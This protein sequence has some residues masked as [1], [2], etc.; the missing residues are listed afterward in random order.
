MLFTASVRL[1][2]NSM[3]LYRYGFNKYEISLVTGLPSQELDK[4]AA[5]LI[6]YFTNDQEFID[7]FVEKDGQPF[8]LFNER[9]IGHLKD[10]KGLFKLAFR[11]L[12][13]TLIYTVV[14]IG[15]VYMLWQDKRRVARGLIGGSALTLGLMAIAGLIIWIDFDWFF[16]QFHFISFANDLWLLD[17]TR[18]YLIMMFPQGFWFDATVIIASGTGA[19]ALALGLTG[20]WRLN[21]IEPEKPAQ[22][23]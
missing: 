6:T 18:D 9:E 15:F 7:V 10:V 19:L 3:T 11:V 20:W 1:A 2:S 21:K 16:R 12:L 5:G 8:Q 14:Y 13:G 23:V 22:K 17:P 4:A